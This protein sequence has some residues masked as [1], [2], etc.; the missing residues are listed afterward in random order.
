MPPSE[1]WASITRNGVRL[2][3]GISRLAVFALMQAGAE[4]E[5][6]ALD[7]PAEASVALNIGLGDAEDCWSE[8][9]KVRQQHTVR[10]VAR[11]A[12]S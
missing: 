6:G 3:L 1:G 5:L 2:P 4:G 10:H 9:A 7:R 8:Q 12:A 11:Y